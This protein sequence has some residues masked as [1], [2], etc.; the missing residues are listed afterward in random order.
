M[1]YA[2]IVNSIQQT[3]NGGYILTGSS[4][5]IL[6]VDALGQEEWANQFA[7]NA[8]H[9]V[10]QTSDGGYIIGGEPFMVYIKT[11]SDRNAPVTGV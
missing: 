2:G 7:F 6:K 8:F 10:Q 4:G 3:I 1:M 9:Y 5:H 11:D